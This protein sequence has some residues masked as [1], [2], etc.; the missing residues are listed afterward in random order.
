MYLTKALFTKLAYYNTLSFFK[1][2]YSKV[3]SKLRLV[4]ET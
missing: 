2:R 1:F 4:T 3:K